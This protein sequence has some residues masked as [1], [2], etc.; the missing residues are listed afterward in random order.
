L[1]NGIFPTLSAKGLVKKNLSYGSEDAALW[2]EASEDVRVI[3]NEV[4][5]SPTGV[6]ITVSKN[7]LVKKNNIHH[8]TVG[9]GLYQANGASLPPLGPDD[10]DWQI[11]GNHIH[12][13]NTPNTAPPGSLSSALPPGA[14]VLLLGVDRVTVKNNLIENND[15][16][17]VAVLDWCVATVLAGP[18]SGFDCTSN[19]PVVEPA[20]NGNSIIGNELVGNASDPP[21]GFEFAAADLVF[22]LGG[23]A[24]DNCMSDNT[25]TATLFGTPLPPC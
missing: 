19:P 20:P 2:V 10:G 4:H 6:E 5:S 1:E 3:K 12:D 16:L 14:G 7:I 24:T 17:G 18:G 11:I 25:P 15:F 23:Q 8:N 21:S 13:N 22:L 9:V